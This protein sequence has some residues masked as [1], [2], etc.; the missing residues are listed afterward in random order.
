MKAGFNFNAEVAEQ[1]DSVFLAAS[2]DSRAR[3][4]QS[5]PVK[6]GTFD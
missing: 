4:S 2:R 5:P 6:P 1:D 3:E